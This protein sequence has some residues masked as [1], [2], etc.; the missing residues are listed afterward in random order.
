MKST[1]HI[2]RLAPSASLFIAVQ[3]ALYGA[4]T[5]SAYAQIEEQ[6]N[7][8]SM[9]RIVI[10]ATRTAR[11]WLQTPASVESIEV[12]D[13]LPGQRTDAAELLAGISGVQV[14]TRYNFAQDTR[15]TL[16]GFGAR[17]AFGVRG[18]RMRLDGIPLSMPDG[19]GQTSSIL[20]NEPYRVEVLRG[21]FAAIYG[22]A[23]GGVIDFQSE[24][25]L[26]S[27]FEAGVS[28]GS[29]NRA[30]EHLRG[31]YVND[32]HTVS[33]DYVDF[34]TNGD[35]PHSSAE[36]TQHA[37]RW[38]WN[39]NP[40]W[41]SILRIDNNRAPNVQDPS[42][43]SPAAWRENPNQVVPQVETFNTRKTTKH[44]QVSL[45]LRGQLNAK[46]RTLMSAWQGTRSIEQYLAFPGSDITA[47]GG[48]VDLERSFSGFSALYSLEPFTAIPWQLTAAIDVEKQEDKRR[49][50]VNE[51]G[52]AGDLRRDE[53]GHVDSLDF[54]LIS[55]WQANDKWAVVA[56]V[57]AS[58]IDFDVADR[59][60]VP[61]NSDN[62]GNPDDSGQVEF[63]EQ[64][65][66]LGL[67]YTIRPTASLFA[68]V[69]EGFET[70]TLTE[71]AY[72]NEGSGLNTSLQTSAV[73]QFDMGLKGLTER[74]RW[75]TSLFYI[76]SSNDL[77][78][79]QSIDGRTT[80][81]NAAKTERYGLEASFNYVFSDQ[82]SL[83]SSATLMRAVFA[84]S[85]AEQGN[86]LPG[87]AR[88]QIFNQLEYRPY[89]TESWRLKLQ[90]NYRSR[91]AI[92]DNNSDFAPSATVWSFSSEWDYRSADMPRWQV[93]PWFRI[94]NISDK[95]YVGSVVVNQGNGRAFEPAP[96]RIWLLGVTLRYR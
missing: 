8:S 92:N 40:N 52:V 46:S 13:Q 88:E 43:L 84:G 33:L 12:Y 44:D 20:L 55:D 9:E 59:F 83:R 39:I 64:S 80:Y 85:T 78:V 61:P 66:S 4:I 75:L 93:Q 27:N 60:I 32:T 62:A 15:I 19:Q 67:N 89:G 90:Q 68:S 81:R 3:I 26:V 94:D 7:N 87:L 91:I 35:R 24:R 1:K 47:S 6:G 65:W 16:R 53:T 30:S 57:R 36:R 25:P 50:F 76:E 95:R 71:M 41:Q 69:G 86:M 37:L 23:S 48:V 82:W 49:G 29:A 63:S 22:N 18:V 72:Q 96:G 73:R 28:T 38:Y 14:D 45:T 2:A 10:T 42:A 79:D 21:P 17:A 74:A 70:P 56:G 54:S 34:S 77:I 58:N 31:V 51:R 5:P 11:P